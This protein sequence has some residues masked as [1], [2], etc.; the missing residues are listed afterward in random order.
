MRV[1]QIVASVADEAAGP[2]YSVP[3]L[4]SALA[5]AGVDSALYALGEA[6][7]TGPTAPSVAYRA[8]PQTGR[9]LPIFREMRVSV[10][11]DRALRDGAASLDVMHSHGL[12]LMPNITPAG[13]ARRAGK[14][15]VLSPRGMLGGPALRFS[16]RRKQL[17]W[18]V[19]QRRA[20]ASAKL[21]HATSEEEC[22]E[23]RAMGLVNPVTVIP[24]GI[25][26]PDLARPARGPI[27]S[28]LSLGR[29]HPKK[30]LDRLIRAWSH[31]GDASNGWRLRI[32]G[33]SEGGC[34]DDLRA[35]VR[36]LNISGVTIED[37]LFGDAKLAAY[38]EADL[39]V[40]PTLNE[41][42]AMTVAEALAAGTPVVSTKGAPWSGLER[43]GCGWWVDHGEASMAEALRDALTRQAGA[44]SAM[45]EKGRSWML[46]DFSWDRV[47]S[48]MLEAYRWIDGSGDRPA[49]IR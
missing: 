23:I 35:L 15:F 16:R 29:V 17:V 14:A 47:G 39:F 45:G 32:V 10:A 19:M 43:E 33:P 27:R 34:A 44:L 4:A 42:F 28:V 37:P 41:N 25:D 38:R 22:E 30:G 26:V 8:F 31:L 21:L 7:G 9:H 24:N 2:S 46:R 5:R 11:L 40:L 1:V 12:W 48:D 18:A 20:V 49:T 36:S 3:R 13:I 6:G